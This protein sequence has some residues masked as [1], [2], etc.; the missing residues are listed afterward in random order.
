V[1]GRV[2]PVISQLCQALREVVLINLA[3]LIATETLFFS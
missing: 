1:C 2:Y 3:L